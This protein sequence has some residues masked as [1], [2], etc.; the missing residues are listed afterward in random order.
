MPRFRHLVLIA[1]LAV[2]VSACGSANGVT[3]NAELNA[4]IDRVI[5]A[6]RD[7]N[8]GYLGDQLTIDVELIEKI[9]ASTV[10]T[11]GRSAVAVTFT[12]FRN[13]SM[14]KVYSLEFRN[15]DPVTSGSNAT[16]TGQL[17][18]D[19]DFYCFDPSGRCREQ[20]TETWVVTLRR[21]GSLWLISKIERFLVGP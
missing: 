14:D 9:G 1:L 21:S 4:V 2:M 8:S 10:I 11:T 15:R 6:F 18:I 5:S 17:Y 3:T 20:N 19:A 7:G 16:M 12:E 13:Q